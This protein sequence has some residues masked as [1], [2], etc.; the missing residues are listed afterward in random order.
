MNCL[1]QKARSPLIGFERIHPN[2]KQKVM[3]NDKFLG[4]ENLPVYGGLKRLILLNFSYN[5]TL[6]F[7]KKNL[8]LKIVLKTLLL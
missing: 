6:F 1:I 8:T 2:S 4:K 7:I 5:C 3:P